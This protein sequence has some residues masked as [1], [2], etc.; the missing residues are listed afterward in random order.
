MNIP[1]GGQAVMKK[2]LIKSMSVFMVMLIVM[3]SLMPSAFASPLATSE[4]KTGDDVVTN[5]DFIKPV[6]HQTTVPNNDL[7][8]CKTENTN[9]DDYCNTTISP[10]SSINRDMESINNNFF[11][12]IESLRR[13]AI[14]DTQF[15]EVYLLIADVLVFLVSPVLWV[16]NA[17]FK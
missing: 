5:Y 3:M 9:N 13:K 4:R 8:T 14:S 12:F 15:G 16:L 1:Q 11:E 6:T 17:I 7:D 10:L 2:N